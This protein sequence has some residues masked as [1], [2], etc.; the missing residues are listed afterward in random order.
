MNLVTLLKQAYKQSA[1]KFKVVLGELEIE[2]NGRYYIASYTLRGS[3][4]NGQV[5]FLVAKKSG[6]LHATKST[7]KGNGWGVISESQI[8]EFTDYCLKTNLESVRVSK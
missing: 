6:A 3:I 2:N 4:L 8:T 7:L 1:K 5:R